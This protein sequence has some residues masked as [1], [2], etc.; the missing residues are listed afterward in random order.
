MHRR[1]ITVFALL[2]VA[3]P[4]AVSAGSLFPVPG[5]YCVDTPVNMPAGAWFGGFD[6]LPNGNFVILDGYAVREI[7][8]AGVDVNTLYT[9]PGYVYGSFV[10]YNPANGRVYFGETSTHAIM[11]VP[12]SGG[13]SSAVANVQFNYDMDFWSGAPYVV[14]G[15]TVY[16]VD[17][18]TGQTDAI[19][20][21]G[22][23]S[24]PVIFDSLGNLIYG[25]GNPNWPPTTNDQKIYMWSAAQVAGAA[26]PTVLGT[27][28]ATVLAAGVDAPTGFAIDGLGR[29]IYTDSQVSPAVLRVVQGGTADLFT[30]T[31]VPGEFPWATVI[32]Y[33]PA[34]DGL[35]VAVS[36]FDSGWAAHTVISTLLPV[37]EPPAMA[38]L[39]G[40]IGLAAPTSLLRRR[41]S[42]G[43]H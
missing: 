13:A 35:S 28:E 20:T 33:N 38:A 31:N 36:W 4:A 29:L 26:G 15:N 37:P 6:V 18:S 40:L 25:T 24:G 2:L 42:A 43:R 32:R 22:V 34:T 23:V 41:M 10:R 16:A 7:T 14:A 9:F 21:A 27:A 17:E 12:A 19:A 8:P 5:Y 1:V 11:S 39:A 30:G 3:V